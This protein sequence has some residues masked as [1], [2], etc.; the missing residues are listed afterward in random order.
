MF[1]SSRTN[2]SSCKR[3]GDPVFSSSRQQQRNYV[4]ASS[5]LRHSVAMHGA[6]QG[7]KL[8]TDQTDAADTVGND[9]NRKSLAR[10]NGISSFLNA[11]SQA[12][13]TT[14]KQSKGFRF[15]AENGPV[16]WNRALAY[17]GTGTTVATTSNVL[18]NS[19]N[20]NQMT[21][22]RN[23]GNES[24]TANRDSF[25]GYYSSNNKPEV[26]AQR[27]REKSSGLR[28]KTEDDNKD[29]KENDYNMYQRGQT[30]REEGSYSGGDIGSSFS[31]SMKVKGSNDSNARQRFTFETMAVKNNGELRSKT[32]KAGRVSSPR[33]DTLAGSTTSKNQDYEPI[34][35][36]M[37]DLISSLKTGEFLQKQSR[38]VAATSTGSNDRQ[39][40]PTT[41]TTT[42]T[43]KALKVND[44][45]TPTVFY[46]SDRRSLE[47]SQA[48]RPYSSSSSSNLGT[49]NARKSFTPLGQT[50]NSMN[51]RSSLALSKKQPETSKA[52]MRSS[53][54]R[55]SLTQR[56]TQNSS[57]D[58]VEFNSPRSGDAV[59]FFNGANK[60]S[61]RGMNDKE[62]RKSVIV[63]SNS[64]Y[65]EDLSIGGMGSPK[66]PR[67]SSFSHL[68][69]S[70]S[71]SSRQE[72][73]KPTSVTKKTTKVVA[74]N[75]PSLSNSNSG[76]LSAFVTQVG[77]KDT[78]KAATSGG[79]TRKKE[80][81]LAKKNDE[82]Y[83]EHLYN[84]ILALRFIKQMATV[85]L[86][87][88]EK[89]KLKLMK[90]VEHQNRK[91]VIFDLDETL[92]H[93]CENDKESAD[94]IVPVTFP[95]G[96]TIEAGINI[97][98]YARECLTVASKYFEVIV[99]TASHSCYA[100]A[101]LNHLDPKG[102]LIH[103][104]LYRENCILTQEGILIKDL[105]VLTNRNLADVVIVDNAVYSFCN[106]LDNG[107]P[108]ITWY[109]N[110]EDCELLMLIAYLDDLRKYKD[111][112]E[113][114]KATFQ[115][116]AFINRTDDEE[117][118]KL[119]EK[120]AR[121]TKM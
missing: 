52:Q 12:A 74:A 30:K 14:S 108:I 6:S 71:K 99:F 36:K 5:S 13:T 53:S 58:A 88:V 59:G 79:V 43:N 38:D 57:N 50:K 110:R 4:P 77:R 2:R 41:T 107:I 90:R 39:K 55:P 24:K 114:N 49:N 28:T 70:G 11:K 27:R 104:R 80:T 54:S 66:N 29:C 26:N 109:D 100:D 68:K 113:L 78:G 31:N 32:P 118:N 21:A 3:Q 61:S 1:E 60:T 96:E 72:V 97:R 67:S 83:K 15:E 111:T 34:M 117:I 101:V 95:N 37:R 47:N 20:F 106:Q 119:C 69:P 23:N 84:T 85:P 46:Q 42:T 62:A 121:E 92:V 51:S 56:M 45:N 48:S 75:A 76:G 19:F 103:H 81:K 8:Q 120:L 116:G 9:I 98:P 64:T 115:L 94:V 82:I 40:F 33:Y 7:L 102:T 10:S 86:E 17:D 105:R 22:G 87:A 35:E 93:C 18:R 44:S 112:R 73:S 16:D 25:A 91:T 89:K 63:T 65:N